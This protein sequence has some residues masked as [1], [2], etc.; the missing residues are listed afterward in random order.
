MAKRDLLSA[1]ERIKLLEKEVVVL[2]R[3]L[4]FLGFYVRNKATFHRAAVRWGIAK[5]KAAG[6]HVGR[7]KRNVDT[8]TVCSLR[9]RGLSWRATAREIGVPVSTV[10]RSLN[11]RTGNGQPNQ[12]AGEDQQ[13]KRISQALLRAAKRCSLEMPKGSSPIRLP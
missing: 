2:R 7:P 9:D 1:D 6:K 5:A 11:P 10:F 3:M 13:W 4:R 12:H 8:R